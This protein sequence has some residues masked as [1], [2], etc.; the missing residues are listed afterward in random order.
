MRRL[1]VGLIILSVTFVASCASFEFQQYNV[2]GS[3]PRMPD[4]DLPGSPRSPSY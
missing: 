1:L 4:R 2:P 3:D